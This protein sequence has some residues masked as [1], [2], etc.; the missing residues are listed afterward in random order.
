M[1][2]TI[3]NYF[4]ADGLILLAIF[5]PLFILFWNMKVMSDMSKG[6]P[7]PFWLKFDFLS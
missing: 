6:K 7:K 1:L 4:K 5:V 2:E 3:I